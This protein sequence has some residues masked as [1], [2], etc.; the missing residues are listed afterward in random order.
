MKTLNVF[1][2]TDVVISS[3]IS[4]TG[5]AYLLLNNTPPDV[6]FWI[7]NFSEKEIIGTINKLNLS[8]IDWKNIKNNFKYIK[9]DQ[10]IQHIRNK[11]LNFILDKNDAQIVAGTVI[12]QARYL[13]TYNLKHYQIEKIKELNIIVLTPGQFLQYLR[14]Q[15]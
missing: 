15:N 2:D 11:Y 7:S 8:Q 5:G 13:L 10:N 1:V 12:S 9:L 4:K 14:S 3:L 6:N